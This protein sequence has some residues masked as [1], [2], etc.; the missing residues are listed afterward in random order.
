MSTHCHVL[1]AGA[2]GVIGRDAVRRFT[3]AGWQVTAL[4]RRDPELDLPYQHKAVD[5]TDASACASLVAQLP[6]ITH[7]V[8]AA[9]Y[10][11]QG[12]VSGWRSQQQMSTNLSMLRNLAEPL[13]QRATLRH[14]SLFQGTKAYG[15]HLHPIDV[16]A[17]ESSPRHP[18]ENF[19]WLQ[20]DYLRELAQLHDF[21]IT[22]WR[23]QVVFGDA[24]GVA[25]N[26][27]PVLGA[28]AALEASMG[29]DL[30]WPGGPGY[31]LE[32]VDSRLIADA[33][34]WAATHEEAQNE[35]FNIT[36]GDVFT[37]PNVWP[38]LANA[39]GATPGG[40]CPQRLSVTL[41]E[42]AH[43][44]HRLA[45]R[46]GLVQ[47]NLDQLLGRSHHYADFV[48]AT[49]AQ[50][51]PEPALVS[52]IKLRQAGFSGCIDSEAMFHQLIARLQAQRV[53]PTA[54]ELAKLRF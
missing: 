20:E 9:V 23:P 40:N 11:E 21:D 54:E 25:M 37:W 15:V 51:P 49:G 53:L 27:L 41:P 14:V 3:A 5:L 18:H 7:V 6:D 28:Y 44:W 26:I 10:E 35:T 39:L 4:S 50:R 42:R 8:Y 13:V 32:A 12:L 29:R 43:E 36:N 48:F 38:T 34:V 2:S 24:Y 19:Y 30:A 17:R 1:I 47:P 33:L 22:I 16:P 31:V 46:L 45:T 52:T